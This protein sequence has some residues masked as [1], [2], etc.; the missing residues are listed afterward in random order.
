VTPE[1]L[2]KDALAAKEQGSVCGMTLVFGR[3]VKRPKGSPRGEFL[4]ET[5]KG[6]VYSFNPDK[7]IS[8]L[9]KNDLV[10]KEVQ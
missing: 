4:S 7:V 3:G 2:Y 6:R 8:W 10:E 1:Q 5:H 9:V